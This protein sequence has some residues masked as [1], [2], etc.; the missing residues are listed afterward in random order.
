MICDVH[1]NSYEYDENGEFI[2]GL[3]ANTVMTRDSQGRIVYYDNTDVDIDDDDFDITDFVKVSYTYDER[4]GS[5]RKN[6]AAGSG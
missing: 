6:T 1:G 5:L 4:A 2:E 3:S